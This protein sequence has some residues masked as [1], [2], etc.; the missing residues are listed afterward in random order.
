[1]PHLTRR[2]AVAFFLAADD[3]W[4]PALGDHYWIPIIIVWVLGFIVAEL[5]NKRMRS[6][7]QALSAFRA[8]VWPSF[9]IC[10][11]SPLLG[12]AGARF[13]MVWTEAQSPWLF[14]A[15]AISIN[16]IA[17]ALGTIVIVNSYLN[18]LRIIGKSVVGKRKRRQELSLFLRIGTLVRDDDASLYTTRQ[19][20]LALE[21]SGVGSVEGYGR[22]GEFFIIQMAGPSAERLFGTLR[23]LLAG[24]SIAPGSFAVIRREDASQEIMIEL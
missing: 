5:I 4:R 20:E 13:I 7:D 24:I 15:V 18:D 6:Q 14:G 21:C 1:M 12:A 11:G 8:N 3:F 10:F 22:Q 23:V 19:I 16:A 9:P 17:A 2:S